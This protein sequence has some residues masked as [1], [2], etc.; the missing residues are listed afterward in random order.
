MTW[1]TGI[2]VYVLT[3][4]VTLFAVLPWGNR[5]PESPL[6]GTADGAPDQ[7]RLWLKFLV[8][9]LVAAVIWGGI[10]AL[11][12]SNVISFREWAKAISTD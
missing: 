2:V 8:T 4:W 9:T 12:E 5:T 3:W 6:P 10:E 1:F 11:V 7:P